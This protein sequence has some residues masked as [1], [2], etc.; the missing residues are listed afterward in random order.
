MQNECAARLHHHAKR[1]HSAGMYMYLVAI[2]PL[3]QPA[4][5]KQATVQHRIA[6]E[7]HGLAR[8]A[9]SDVHITCEQPRKAFVLAN[10]MQPEKCQKF[11]TW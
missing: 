7:M 11:S 6:S 1:A 3:N 4:R 8:S 5:Q 10:S 9:Q 2:H